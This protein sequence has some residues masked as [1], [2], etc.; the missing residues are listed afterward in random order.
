MLSPRCDRLSLGLSL[1]LL[2]VPA[3]AQD[4][5]TKSSDATTREVHGTI[6][7]NEAGAD[8][9]KVAGEVTV[10][11]STYTI[12]YYPRPPVQTGIGPR[13]GLI[14][15]SQTPPKR[16]PNAKVSFG[17]PK[18][19]GSSVALPYRITNLPPGKLIA[20]KVS[21]SG[22]TLGGVKG[23]FDPTLAPNNP[24]LNYD[25]IFIKGLSQ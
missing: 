5:R 16:L 14:P 19:S 3:L 18:I 22:A 20:V 15:S 10:T 6:L 17:A 2:A 25:F 8:A 21:P 9:T 7:W 1:V 4:P 11:A 24:S 23:N 13:T 12:I